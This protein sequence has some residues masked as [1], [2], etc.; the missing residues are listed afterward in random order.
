DAREIPRAD[1]FCAEAVLDAEVLTIPDASQDE[2]FASSPFVAGEN[3]WRFY[4][5]VPLINA[6]GHALGAL[7]VGDVR[8]RN[9]DGDQQRALQTLA[10]QIIAQLELRR[11]LLNLERELAERKKTET[12]LRSSEERFFKAFNANPE[13]MIISRL[14]DGRYL[15][16]NESFLQVTGWTREAVIGCNALELNLWADVGDSER[17]IEMLAARGRIERE[18]VEFR[19]RTGETRTGLFSAE[20][21]EIDGE[22]CILSLATDITERK[23]TEEA[24]RKSEEYRNLFRLANDAILVSD[25]ESEAILDVNEKACAV[26]GVAREELIGKKVTDLFYGDQRKGQ[27]HA[28]SPA[29]E[30]ANQSF[31]VLHRRADDSPLHFLVNSSLIEYRGR[32]ALLSI[33]RDI[34]ERKHAE[35][36]RMH[37]AF[38]DPLTG[39]PNRAL[40]LDHLKLAVERA[41]RREGTHLFAVLFLDLDRF[42]VVNDSLG[43]NVGDQLLITIARRLESCLRPGDTVARLGGDEFT[44]LLDDIK[45]ASDAI[46]LAK[47]IQEVLRLPFNLDEHEVFTTVSIGIALSATDYDQPEDL[48]RDADTAMYRAKS[49]GKARHEV[50]DKPMHARAMELLQLEI[51]LRRAIERQE[52]CI[53]YQPIISLESGRI[54]GF[55]ALVRWKH[56]ERGLITPEKFIPVAEETGLIV[57]IGQL[58]LGE[59]CRQMR[60]WQRQ[61]PALQPLSIS[62]N[63]SSKQL[64]Q[65]DLIEQIK[66]SLQRSGLDPLSLKL[67]ITESVVMENTE[68]AINMLTQLRALQ[69]GLSIDDFGTGYS[70]LSYLHRFPVGTLKIDRSFVSRLGHNDENGEIVKTIIMLAQ[71]LKM[72]VVAEGVETDDQMLHLRKLKCE[73]VQGYLISR[74]V[75]VEAAGQMLRNRMEHL[76]TPYDTTTRYQHNDNPQHQI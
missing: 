70:S 61:Y 12:A 68:T 4:A 42:K 15:F 38:H 3:G 76:T 33:N 16:V 5:A 50:F 41:R 47:L 49:L 30:G 64:T 13:P 48:L 66:Q 2:R 8:P 19:L 54:C 1:S 35:E 65:P 43:H 69:V 26:Y 57:P 52:F 18:E 22:R 34:T 25:V 60:R 9:L 6:E 59:A 36:Q 63:L 31:E 75:D 23:K 29:R 74:P 56:P 14:E 55:E 7:C 37:D 44:M 51:D 58:V 73:Y 39:L 45:D 72:D 11:N 17:L 40:F 27:H 28:P 46:R 24:L 32:P 20:I 62:V 67:E 21:I 71:N 53:H 10:R